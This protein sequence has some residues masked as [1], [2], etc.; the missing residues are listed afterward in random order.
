[1]NKILK[2]ALILVFG[3]S[4]GNSY[5]QCNT[6]ALASNCV[7]KV[8]DGFTFLKSFS[9]D[10]NSGSREKVEY[11]YVF[12]KDTQYYL[13]ICSGGENTDGIIVTIFDSKRRVASTNFANNKIFP[14][15]IFACKATG[16][17]YITFTFED[18]QQF[19]GGSVLAFKK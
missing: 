10:G 7:S 1:M 15:I 5:G 12:S 18:S 9:I 8:Q 6:Q 13:N 14:G 3:L 11:S 4:F 17:Y 16:I 19:C 2:S